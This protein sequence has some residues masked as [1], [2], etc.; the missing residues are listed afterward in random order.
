MHY[1]GSALTLLQIPFAAAEALKVALKTK[2]KEDIAA[3]VWALPKGKGK[4]I[5]AAAPAP[6]TPTAAATNEQ[7]SLAQ[8]G[9]AA[10]KTLAATAKACGEE[11]NDKEEEE[12]E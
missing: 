8:R 2:F 10:L 3:A 7:L 11:N 1:L 6:L 4:A 9:M 5:A 12:E